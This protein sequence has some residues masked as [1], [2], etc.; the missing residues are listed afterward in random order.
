MV[1]NQ[2]VTG[3]NIWSLAVI[4]LGPAAITGA[5]SIIISQLQLKMKISEIK[6]ESE[7]KAR[8][9]LFRLY[10]EKLRAGRKSSEEFFGSIGKTFG[11]ITAQ[12]NEQEGIKMLKAQFKLIKLVKDEIPESI[13]GLE[14][15]LRENKLFTEE[16]EK[17]IS[18]IKKT[19]SIDLE[20]IPEKDMEAIFID[21]CKVIDLLH[22]FEN[23]L[24]E[25][26]SNKLFSKYLT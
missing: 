8:E 24:L 3:V 19:I 7:Y 26:K 11:Y 15:E 9:N 1:S 5:V 16:I 10:Q 2:V 14:R 13:D 21:Y 18:F 20:K 6:G 17:Q 12:E 25:D 22:S 4:M 23:T